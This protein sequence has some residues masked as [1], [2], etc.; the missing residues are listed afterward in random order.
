MA[1]RTE[2]GGIYRALDYNYGG[3]TG[4]PPPL[5]LISA[6]QSVG[7]GTAYLQ[8]ARLSLSD[9][10]PVYP[11]ATTAPIRVGS[12][13]N[14]ELVTPSAVG[15][16]RSSIP[17]QPSITANFANL[18]GTGDPVASGTYGLQEALNAAGAAGGGTV[19][20]DAA[21]EAAGGTSGMISGATLP[22][23][24]TI[25][26]NRAGGGIGAVDSVTGTANEITAS[27][28]T[29]AVVLSLPAVID[30]GSKTSLEIPNSAAPATTV[31]GQIAGDNNAWGAGRGAVQFFDGTANTYLVGALASDT[32]SNGQVPTWNMGGTITWETPGGGGSSI[33]AGTYAALPAPGTAGDMYL[34]TDGPYTFLDDGAAWDALVQGYGAVTLPV[35]GDFAW[36]NQQTAAV[37]DTSGYIQMSVPVNDSGNED[38]RVR[39]KTAPATPY[40]V[41]AL[42]ST[43]RLIVGDF[44]SVGLYYRQS[45]D[46]KLVAF[47]L[48]V[49]SGV[50]NL[51]VTKLTDATTFSAH[52]AGNVPI[53]NK[54]LLYLRIAD[55]GVNRICSWS[56]DGNNFTEILS[57]GRTDFLTADQVGW[58]ANGNATKATGVNL[59]S[60]VEA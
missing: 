32:P 10:T 48:L 58:G 37:A 44:N 16:S 34:Q 6:P 15:A 5:Q 4:F 20:V 29:G 17:G 59:L 54:G 33:T 57:V 49:A 56:Q 8:D 42:V 55:D 47:Q 45:S 2:F 19:I 35:N 24:V 25:E 53:S 46:G 3:G 43:D 12:G 26:D 9:G 27:P 52:Y 60:W 39:V 1:N 18:H 11:L 28:V 38:H 51:Y 22:S 31:F 21:W 30:L 7:V 40:T 14:R 50:W 23:D 36:V 41:T 13:G